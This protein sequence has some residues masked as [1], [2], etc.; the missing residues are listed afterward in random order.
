[1]GGQTKILG[2]LCPECPPLGTGLPIHK[3]KLSLC[4][5]I[6]LDTAS[7][8]GNSIDLMYTTKSDRWRESKQRESGF[9]LV[10]INKQ[11]E[12]EFTVGC[13]VLMNRDDLSSHPD[14]ILH[15]IHFCYSSPRFKYC[16]LRN[17]KMACF[18][19]N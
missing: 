16:L 17:L 3:N 4:K 14:Y 1:M 10:S 7:N 18:S 15:R 8:P 5:D 11:F 2:G 12:Q 9:R 19:T 13:C 6:P